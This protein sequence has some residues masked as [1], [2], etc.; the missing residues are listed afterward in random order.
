MESTQLL[1]LQDAAREGCIPFLDFLVTVLKIDINTPGEQGMTPLHIAVLSRQT[2]MV[3]HMLETYPTL[4]RTPTDY[5]ART[6][7]DCAM[8]NCDASIAVLLLRE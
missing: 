5:L 7:L 3:K 1:L 4:N 2:M 6:P 8:A